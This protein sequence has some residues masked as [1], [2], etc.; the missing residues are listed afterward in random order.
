MQENTVPIRKKKP[1]EE[2]ILGEDYYMEGDYW[3]FTEKYHLDK[4]YCCGSFCRHCPYPVEERERVAAEK[5]A[6]K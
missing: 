5:K 2:C 1:R 3:V 6:R 4:G